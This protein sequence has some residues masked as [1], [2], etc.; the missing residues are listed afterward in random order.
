MGNDTGLLMFRQRYPETPGFKNTTTSFSAA[1][2]VASGAPKLRL[3]ALKAIKAS[4]KGLTADETAAVAG[5][6]VLSIRPRVTELAKNNLVFDSG[7][8]RQNVSGRKAIVWV[9][10]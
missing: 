10:A 1:I 4:E 7:Q 2:E 8:R 3:I 5:E 6:S 9:A